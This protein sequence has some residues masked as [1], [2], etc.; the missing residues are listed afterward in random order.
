MK[1]RYVVAVW[2]ALLAAFAVGQA[3]KRPEYQLLQCNPDVFTL[4]F[5]EPRVVV[6]ISH[7]E[8]QRACKEAR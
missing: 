8:V 4:Y 5:P 6:I 7:A 2:I 1:L 3:T